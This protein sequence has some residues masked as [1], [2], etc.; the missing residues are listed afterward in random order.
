MTPYSVT[1]PPV[2]VHASTLEQVQVVEGKMRALIGE[3]ERDFL[4]G[5]VITI[6]PGTPH[7][8]F[9][10][11]D[12]VAVTTVASD[13]VSEIL[14]LCVSQLWGMIND[15]RFHQAK[16]FFVQMILMSP[17][18]DVWDESIPIFA[19]RAIS[20]VVAPTARLL[21]YRVAYPEYTRNA[22]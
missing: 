14:G 17:R 3:T 11:G 5:E 22:N 16:S 13:G 19:Q 2:H 9:N 12:S 10:A 20:F 15:P 4:P 7:K 6:P 8:F 1:G 18:C 21:G